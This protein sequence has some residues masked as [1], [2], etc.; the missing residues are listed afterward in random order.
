MSSA[1]R[2]FATI[3]VSVGLALPATAQVAGPAH[4][5]RALGSVVVYIRSERG[6]P[7]SIVP[8]ITLTSMMY[9]TPASSFPQTT[10]NGW[11]FSNVVAGDGFSVEVKADGYETAHE[12]VN[13]PAENG[14]SVSV[15][16]F[17]KKTDDRLAIQPPAGQFVLAPPGRLSGSNSD[18]HAGS[19]I[20]S[21]VLESTMDAG[22]FLF[23]SERL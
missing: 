5:G 23:V 22:R 21:V 1:L 4:V 10:G 17:M 9:G 18:P 19:A 13:L 6:E 16:V 20:G 8:K 3:L 15:I 11:V 12:T 2:L 14:T 7:L